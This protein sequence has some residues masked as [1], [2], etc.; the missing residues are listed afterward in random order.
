MCIVRVTVARRMLPVLSKNVPGLG[1]VS[2]MAR[3]HIELKK[4]DTVFNQLDRHQ[5]IRERAQAA[6][7]WMSRSRRTMC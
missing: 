7:T 5:A 6:G 1:E 4:V 3:G 2:A